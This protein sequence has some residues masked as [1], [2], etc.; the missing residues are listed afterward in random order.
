MLIP[1]AFVLVFIQL[2][3]GLK[4]C[5][6]FKEN[7]YKISYGYRHMI[8]EVDAY[9][10]YV[11]IG[12][13][14][15]SLKHTDNADDKLKSVSIEVESSGRSDWFG[16]NYSMAICLLFNGKES[17]EA[18]G[19]HGI[20][21]LMK[22]NSKDI[23][24]ALLDKDLKIIK[25]LKRTTLPYDMPATMAWVMS[26][27]KTK[28][29][30]QNLRHV[31]LW[32]GSQ[33]TGRFFGDGYDKPENSEDGDTRYKLSGL[34]KKMLFNRKVIA[35]LGQRADGQKDDDSLIVLFQFDHQ[36]KYCYADLSLD[37][38]PEVCEDKNLK[39]LIDCNPNPPPT[40]T[41]SASPSPSPL[42]AL[43][44]LVILIL[45]LVVVMYFVYKWF[46]KGKTDDNSGQQS[47]VS[48]VSDAQRSA[49][50]TQKKGTSVVP[51]P[52]TPTK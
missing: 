28:P 38:M 29:E 39:T 24:W 50:V 9:R 41:P 19:D 11:V 18:Q 30:Y 27:Q 8:S 47:N 23:D 12:H 49:L 25:R 4:F 36:I 6:K 52:T 34:Y 5:E 51:N 33:I 17:S 46:T 15:W 20:T 43:V 35:V 40:P 42:I 48:A 21:G 1:L 3:N 26:Y 2:G 31:L 45:V 44:I 13:D 10:Q 16:A 32:D 14:F 22:T 37:I 7:N